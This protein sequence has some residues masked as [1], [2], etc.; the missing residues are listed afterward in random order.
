L[1]V[2]DYVLALSCVGG[3]DPKGNGCPS[4]VQWWRKGVMSRYEM[5]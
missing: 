4:V 5:T 3:M 2:E 1:C